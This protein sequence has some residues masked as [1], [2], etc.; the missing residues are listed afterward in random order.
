MKRNLSIIKLQVVS[1]TFSFQVC[2]ESE[3]LQTA[4]FSS[5]FLCVRV[6]LISNSRF[7][8]FRNSLLR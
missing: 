3:M 5:F 4:L 8:T 7:F 6:V 2:L 1:L